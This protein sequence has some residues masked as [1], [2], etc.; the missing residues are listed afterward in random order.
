MRV[1]TDLTSVPPHV[2]CT[3]NADLDP[4]FWVLEVWPNAE[5]G[6]ECICLLADSPGDFKALAETIMAKVSE[7]PESMWPKRTEAE[8]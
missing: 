2:T 6:G 5:D 1:E 7:W 3:I 4:P 8:R